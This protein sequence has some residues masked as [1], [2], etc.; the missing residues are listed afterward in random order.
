MRRRQQLGGRHGP[1]ALLLLAFVALFFCAFAAIA[2]EWTPPEAKLR[3]WGTGRWSSAD[4]ARQTGVFLGMLTD[5]AYT[6]DI[7]NHYPNVEEA[8]FAGLFCGENPGAACLYRFA[9]T[10]FLG[11]TL[12]AYNLDPP[13]R[14]YWQYGA[15]VGSALTVRNHKSLGLKPR[16]PVLGVRFNFF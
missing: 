10:F 2:Q 8:G 6:R 14:P 15:M 13:T 16:W 4:T 12:I 7:G 1:V 9:A 11:H 3:D 5:V